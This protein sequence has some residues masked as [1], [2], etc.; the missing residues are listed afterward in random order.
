MNKF[1]YPFRVPL[2]ILTLVFLFG[3]IISRLDFNPLEAGLGN[4]I[5]TVYNSTIARHPV[6]NKMSNDDLTH[7]QTSIPINT[8]N[9]LIWLGN[10]HL[11]AI[12]N[13]FEGQQL[14]SV[15]LHKMLNGDVWPG[16][17]PV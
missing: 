8:D 3:Y 2:L 9:L 13:Y 14:S 12:N 7:W 6:R 16:K 11:H 10:S 4:K 1:I 17:I 5:I 15:H